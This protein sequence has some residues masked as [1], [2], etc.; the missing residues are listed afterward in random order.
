M[1]KK[2]TTYTAGFFIKQARILEKMTI[3]QLAKK[4]GVSKGTI[5]KW[6]NGYIKN[7][8]ID[9]VLKL[10][11]ILGI[12]PYDIFMSPIYEKESKV[13]KIS[14][15]EAMKE[16]NELVDSSDMTEEQKNMIKNTT[17]FVVGSKKE[18]EK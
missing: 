17:S 5:S 12:D 4:M 15:E 7:M 10:S 8:G 3:E 6:E 2:E 1:D 11:R 18:E 13:Y 16:I 9:K 14:A